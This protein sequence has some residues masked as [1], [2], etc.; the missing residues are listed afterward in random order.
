VR[1]RDQH[2]AAAPVERGLTGTGL[3]HH[4]GA[5]RVVTSL[6]VLA[7]V[8]V[9]WAVAV[10]V[11]AYLAGSTALASARARSDS[12]ALLVSVWTHANAAQAALDAVPSFDLSSTNPDF[13]GSKQTADQYSVQLDGDLTSVQADETLL[14][15]D[16]VR[17]AN[18]A[19][20]MLAQPFRSGLDS[21][22]R[23]AEELLSAIRAEDA[24]LLI[25]GI[26]ARTLSAIFDAASDFSVVFVDHVERLDVTGAVALYPGLVTKLKT[27]AQLASGEPTPLRSKSSSRTC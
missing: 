11:L 3:N 27:A 19:S 10:G 15:A 17:L 16:Q 9:L 13:A 7:A 18:R 20:G 26:Q 5:P 23:R 12:T 22:R 24:A 25:V 8:G 4:D 6:K 21:E 14:R 2:R 1:V